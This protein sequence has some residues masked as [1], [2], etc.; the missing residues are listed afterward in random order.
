MNNLFKVFLVVGLSGF[1]LDAFSPL[2]FADGP[3]DNIPDKVRR[4]PRLGIKVADEDRRKLK[5]GLANLKKQIEI[6]K[7]LRVDSR[8][9]A[10]INELLPDVLIYFR[11][12]HDALVSG[13]DSVATGG[14]R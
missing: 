1:F 14:P 5:E 2:T 11:A 4:I 6:V 9:T 3:A 7:K 10:Q 8:R 12:V 13:V